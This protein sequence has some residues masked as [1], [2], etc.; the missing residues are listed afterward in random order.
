VREK[1]TDLQWMRCSLGQTWQANTKTCEGEAGQFNHDQAMELPEL[2]NQAGGYAGFTDW[3]TPNRGDLSILV[4]FP[5]GHFSSD[6]ASAFGHTKRCFNSL[7]ETKNGRPTIANEV[8]PNT[9][10]TGFWSASPDANLSYGAWNVSFS[11]GD[12][13]LDYKLNAYAVR[14]VRGGQ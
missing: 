7:P 10:Y 13:D 14:L 6:E 2:M 12:V 1:V 9:P 5:D 11:L 4:Y 3:R 8:F